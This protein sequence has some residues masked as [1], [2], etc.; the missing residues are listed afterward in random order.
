MPDYYVNQR[1]DDDGHNEVHTSYCH[2]FSI[3]QNKEYLG[4]YD[5]CVPAVA[6]AKRLGYNANGCIHC[7]KPCH[8]G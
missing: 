4:H 1:K 2:L 6:E 7:S 8:T 3:I 5:T